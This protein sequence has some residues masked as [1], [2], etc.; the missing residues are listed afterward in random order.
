MRDAALLEMWL[1]GMA[2]SGHS[3]LAAIQYWHEQE[4]VERQWLAQRSKRV[5]A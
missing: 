1:V 5:A 3:T 2:R 4:M